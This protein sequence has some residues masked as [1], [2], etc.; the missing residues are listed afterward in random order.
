MRKVFLIL[1]VVD[2]LAFEFLEENILR[3]PTVADTRVLGNFKALEFS[4]NTFEKRGASAA[5]SSENNQQLSGIDVAVEVAQDLLLRGMA[6]ALSQTKG[7]HEERA[8]I[9]LELY[10]SAFA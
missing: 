7:E 2:G 3:N 9:L 8:D 6:E 10:G 1:L 5:W 4:T